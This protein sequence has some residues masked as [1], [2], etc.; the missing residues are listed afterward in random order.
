MFTVPEEECKGAS[1]AE[2]ATSH[3]N[4]KKRKLPPLPEESKKQRQLNSDCQVLYLRKGPLTRARQ[5][6][7]L[8]KEEEVFGIEQFEKLIYRGFDDD[9]ESDE[10]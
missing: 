6:F 1:A 5:P 10:D 3:I 7:R 2:T 4:L 9:V 8:Y